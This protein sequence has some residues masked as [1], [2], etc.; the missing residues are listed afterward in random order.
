MPRVHRIR[1]HDPCH[2]L[3]VRIHV[4]RRH[5]F[6]RSDE[7]DQ[8][9]RVTSG[10]SFKLAE[11]HL[12]RIANDAA[13][14]S[15]K[16][17]I[18]NRTFPGHPCC[19]R[20]NFINIHVW[21][22][23]NAALCRAAREVVLH[24]K[25]FEHLNAARVHARRNVNLQLAIRHAHHGVQIRIEIEQ[26]RRAIEPRHHRFEW[27]VFFDFSNVVNE[28]CRHSGSPKPLND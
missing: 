11:R 15:P 5:V 7:V 27:V 4:G 12:R 10:H 6:L 14:R 22:I 9:R 1:I 24:T 28:S 21:R 16:R 3:F 13:L 19:K 23:T 17:N 2:R 26:L 20:A 25:A 18:H 8:L